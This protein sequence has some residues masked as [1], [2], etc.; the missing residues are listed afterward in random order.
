MR[1]KVNAA[2]ANADKKRYHLL[3]ELRGLAVVAMV[4]FHALFLLGV[5]FGYQT[6]QH[7]LRIILPAQPF[8]AGTFILVCGICCRL[9]RSNLKRGLRIALFA[10]GLTLG[11]LLITLVGIHQV[12]L[13]G[14]LHFLAAAILLFCL[15]AKPLRKI[16]PLVQLPVFTAL[17]FAA[18][19]ITLPQ[20]DSLALFILGFPSLA[21]AS[22][23]YFPLLPWLFL[24]LAGTSI[25]LWAEQG[26]FPACF[27]QP[28]CAP[29]RWAGRHA[30]WIYLAHQPVLYA[31]VMAWQWLT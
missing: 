6:A 31:L 28:R 26:R 5:V 15:A 3:D 13:F 21:W 18:W 10:L 4:I 30:I 29:L 17:F 2:T 20:T 22:A 25:G 8:I 14:V 12:I 27:E 19:F 1:K 23:D 16:H 24:F 11:T 9:S 7:W